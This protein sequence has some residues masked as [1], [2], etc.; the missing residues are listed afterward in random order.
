M[1]YGQ[2]VNKSQEGGESSLRS[3]DYE[4]NYIAFLCARMICGKENISKIICE[5]RNDIEVIFDNQKLRSYQ[6]KFT[7]DNSLRL[8]K[9]YNSIDLFNLLDNIGD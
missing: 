7:S 5:F 9:V 4:K 8:E 2:H 1:N 3:F 6:I